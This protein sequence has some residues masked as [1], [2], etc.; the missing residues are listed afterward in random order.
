MPVVDLGNP[1]EAAVAQALW[2]AAS[3]VGFFSV[4]NHGIPLDQIYD[5]FACSNAFFAQSLEDKEAQSPF[6][7]Q[8]NSGFEH[9]TQVRPSTGLP[10]V[11]ES[12]QITARGEAMVG[13]TLLPASECDGR[14]KSSFLFLACRCLYD[15]P[16][17]PAAVL[18]RG[19]DTRQQKQKSTGD[20][21]FLR[22][23]LRETHL[24]A[25][26][27]AGGGLYIAE[28][29][30]PAHPADFESRSR[31][32]MTAAHSLGARILSLLEPRACPNNVPAGKC[33]PPLLCFVLCA[34]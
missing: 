31:G 6:K 22:A 29:R 32:F 15:P 3:T 8:L 18:T 12:M 23:H 34:L 1:D 4:V 21:I 19:L 7:S 20:V 11:K 27:E 33:A 30:W 16:G 13:L 2:E 25:R 28:G 9:M 10:D 26:V 5:T 24:P 17:P 14:C